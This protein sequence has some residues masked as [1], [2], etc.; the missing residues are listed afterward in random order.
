MTPRLATNVLVGAMVRKAQA[1]G[2]FAAVLAKG[3]PN[4]GS[5]I[6]IL[7]ERGTDPR[8]LERLLLADGRYG[9][10]SSTGLEIDDPAAV[11]GF[12]AR[13]RRSDP[14]LWVIELDI[15]SAKRFA[16]EMTAFG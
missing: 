7:T 3:D 1:E 16:D 6:V 5:V 13:R 2:G 14:D 12:I 9:W 10:Q 4:S 11:P 8:I 15:P